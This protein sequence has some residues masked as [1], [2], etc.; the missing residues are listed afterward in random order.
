MPSYLLILLIV[1]TSLLLGPWKRDEVVCVCV[2]ECV[3]ACACGDLGKGREDA[4][5]SLITVHDNQPS[6]T[7]AAVSTCKP[8]TT[9]HQSFYLRIATDTSRDSWSSWRRRRR[10][11]TACS[12]RSG[13]LC[14][15]VERRTSGRPTWRQAVVAFRK[16][17]PDDA[18]DGGRSRVTMQVIQE[19]EPEDACNEEAGEP[20]GAAP[21]STGRRHL[22]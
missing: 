1:R 12:G 6:C 17:E 13:G 16:S 7:G 18:S 4:P 22:E 8:L 21:S 14:G 9:P 5:P 11:W 10:S 3:C 19:A 2:S 20:G 15:R